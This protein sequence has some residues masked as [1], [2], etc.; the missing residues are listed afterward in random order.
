MSSEVEEVSEDMR[1]ELEDELRESMGKTQ[2]AFLDIASMSTGSKV[3]YASLVALFFA[4]V[5]S[6]FYSLLFAEQEDAAKA[7]RAKVQQRKEKR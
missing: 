4:V 1:R 2:V 5:G 7:H 3:L 6:V